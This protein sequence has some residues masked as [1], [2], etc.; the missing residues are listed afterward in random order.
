MN[1]SFRDN[2]SEVMSNN[3]ENNLNSANSNGEIIPNSQAQVPKNEKYDDFDK[4]TSTMQT[5]DEQKIVEIVEIFEKENEKC[6]K[7][8]VLKKNEKDEQ[9]K[10]KI[11]EK[12][13]EEKEEKNEGGNNEI[14]RKAHDEPKK[15]E[16]IEKSNE[17]EE[18]TNENVNVETKVKPPAAPNNRQKKVQFII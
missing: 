3:Q 11:V 18:K 17:E 6:G 7:D 9:I 12:L 16:Q 13:N 2:P 5:N 8:E 15:E 4:E 14:A 1:N 10:E